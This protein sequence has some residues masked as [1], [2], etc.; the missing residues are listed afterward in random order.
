MSARGRYLIM[1][2]PSLSWWPSCTHTAFRLY[3]TEFCY[4]GNSPRLFV[5]VPPALQWTCRYFPSG[6]SLMFDMYL[7]LMKTL[8]VYL[9]SI[10]HQFSS[11]LSSASAARVVSPTRIMLQLRS[12]CDNDY[13]DMRC[14]PFLIPPVMRSDRTWVHEI[15]RICVCPTCIAMDM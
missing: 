5:Y 7:P 13:W 11:M 3:Q 12:S 6:S 14:L 9:L 10:R 1:P 4:P 15:K 2:L 8:H